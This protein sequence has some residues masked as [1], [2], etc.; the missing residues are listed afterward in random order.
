MT[1]SLILA[2][3]DHN[4]FSKIYSESFR[5]S[6]ANLRPASICAFLSREELVGAARFQSVTDGGLLIAKKLFVSLMSFD[7]SLVHSIAEVGM[8]NKQTK[9]TT[10]YLFIDFNPCGAWLIFCLFILKLNYHKFRFFASEGTYKF[11]R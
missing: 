1:N 11:R 8:K 3:S 10:I 9:K 7:S 4:T 2:S 6:L 5:C